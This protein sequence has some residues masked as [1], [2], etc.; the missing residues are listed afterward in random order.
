MK[1]EIMIIGILLLSNFLYHHE[2]GNPIV[3]Y[4]L[5]LASLLVIILGFF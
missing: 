1:V 4:G 5:Y 3:Q 2:D